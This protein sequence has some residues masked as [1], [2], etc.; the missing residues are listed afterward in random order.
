MNSAAVLGAGYGA[1][2]LIAPRQVLTVVGADPSQSGAV[3][4]ARILGARHLA[5]ATLA[6]RI[7]R[8]AALIDGVHAASMLALAAAAPEHR[9]AALSSAAAAAVLAVLASRGK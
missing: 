8:G 5:Q 2:L 7:P 6:D 3:L 9:R 1:A 4:A